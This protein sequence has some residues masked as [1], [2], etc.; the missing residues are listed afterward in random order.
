MHFPTLESEFV[1][2]LLGIRVEVLPT[3]PSDAAEV[4][5]VTLNWLDLLLLACPKVGTEQDE[6]VGWT[7]DLG[8]ALLY[9]PLS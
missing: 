6:G 7:R 5:V 8:F 1:V 4:A 3:V 2:L 9:L